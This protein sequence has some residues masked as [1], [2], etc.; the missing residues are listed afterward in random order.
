M[1]YLNILTLHRIQ[2][3]D[4]EMHLKHSVIFMDGTSHALS[5]F[6]LNFVKFNDDPTLI[7]EQRWNY[8][9]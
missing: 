2:L 6:S 3:K 8:I 4:M 1:D 9:T 5:D 7:T